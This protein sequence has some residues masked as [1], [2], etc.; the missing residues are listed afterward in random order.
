M[1]MGESE[2]LMN[3]D[4]TQSWQTVSLLRKKNELCHQAQLVVD[5]EAIAFDSTLLLRT[6]KDK[7][8]FNTWFVISSERSESQFDLAFPYAKQIQLGV[9]LS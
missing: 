1:L 4:W 5:E 2:V 6:M 7:N 3:Y 8:L 9:L